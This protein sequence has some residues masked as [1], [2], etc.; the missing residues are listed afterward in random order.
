MHHTWESEDTPSTASTASQMA[1]DETM[2]QLVTQVGLI[3][4]QLAEMG[5]KKVH[6]VDAARGQFINSS[7]NV[8][9]HCAGKGVTTQEHCAII[10]QRRNRIMLET[11]KVA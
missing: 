8:C 2:A 11:T 7:P 1:R 4:K 10:L 3:S 6:V 5:V 9:A